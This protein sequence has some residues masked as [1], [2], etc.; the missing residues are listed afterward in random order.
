MIDDG[1]EDYTPSIWTVVFVPKEREVWFDA[2]SPKWAR[3]VLAFGYVPAVDAYIL[4]DPVER[5][6]QVAIVPWA[7]MRVRMMQ[8]KDRG[9][10][11][12]RIEQMPGGTYNARVGNWCTQTIARLVGVKSSAL[13]PVALYRDLL[14]AG[15]YPVFED[16]DVNQNESAGDQGRPGN[17]ETPSAG[18]TTG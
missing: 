1:W 8:W 18:G 14:K 7:D 12:L 6:H 17:G 15:A 2:L 4:V 16:R 9:V 5:A 10:R 11:A 3:H 13:R